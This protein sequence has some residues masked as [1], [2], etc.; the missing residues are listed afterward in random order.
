MVH[1][2]LFGSIERFFAV[3][4]E[5]FNGAFPTWLAPVQVAVLPVAADFA[6]YAHEVAAALRSDRRACRGG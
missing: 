5:S 3:M 4:L 2:A 1:R 6:D